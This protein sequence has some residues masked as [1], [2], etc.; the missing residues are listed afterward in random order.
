M[1]CRTGKQ[2]DPEFGQCLAKASLTL[3]LAGGFFRPCDVSDSFATGFYK[4][5]GS[6]SA[7]L[8]VVNTNRAKP[9]AG[10]NT[11]DQNHRPIHPPEDI[12][13]RS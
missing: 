6:Q 9:F 3:D 4:R 1:A 13:C 5:T 2:F 7:T 8:L 12:Q 11:C 10:I